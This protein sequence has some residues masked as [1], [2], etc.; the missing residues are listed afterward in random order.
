MSTHLPNDPGQVDSLSRRLIEKCRA[1]GYGDIAQQF[2]NALHVGSSALETLGAIRNTLLQ[3]GDVFRGFAET[4]EVN[5]ALRQRQSSSRTTTEFQ[6]WTKY[7]L[8]V[9]RRSKEFLRPMATR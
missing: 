8:S 5:A 3:H 1:S 7:A 2:D 6:Q 4:S 9:D